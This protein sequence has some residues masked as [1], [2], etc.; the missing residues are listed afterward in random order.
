MIAIHD[1][2]WFSHHSVV[3]L[4]LNQFEQHACV[5]AFHP[6]VFEKYQPL[7]YLNQRIDTNEA[8]LVRNE[9]KKFKQKYKEEW[10][11]Y[12]KAEIE[13]KKKNAASVKGYTKQQMDTYANMKQSV[14]SQ[15]GK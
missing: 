8:I 6:L 13:G 15:K 4:L 9:A 10:N 1:A 11:I 12:V 2:F 3:R 7:A 5:C 14:Y